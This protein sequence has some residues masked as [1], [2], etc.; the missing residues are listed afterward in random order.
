MSR[1]V[2]AV[3]RLLDQET[4]AFKAASGIKCLKPC[5]QC[6]F[7]STVEASE[8]EM[9]PLAFDLVRLG[10]A[11]EWYERA[12]EAGF[13]GI[14]VFYNTEDASGQC[15]LY[16]FRPLVCRLFGFA[17]NRDKHGRPRLVTCRLIKKE[18]PQGAELV[19]DKVANGAIG[20]PMMS[21]WMMRVASVDPEMART[22]FPVNRA[23]GKAVERVV[24][25]RKFSEKS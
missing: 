3:Y 15:R 23:F 7:D 12:E 20:I 13:A 17:G 5:G 24:L 8:L 19:L 18:D 21:D 4:A 14:C 9:L 6:C 2:N 25:N 10:K 1:R 11:D 22:S 16:P